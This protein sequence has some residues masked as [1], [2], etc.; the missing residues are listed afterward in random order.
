M[1]GGEERGSKGTSKEN[2]EQ[3]LYWLAI[4]QIPT[5]P[6]QDMMVSRQTHLISSSLERTCLFLV[7]YIHPWVQ[8][9]PSL[10]M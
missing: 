10:S 3:S 5:D 8:F 2:K 7:S 4:Q 6:I 9:N 1:R